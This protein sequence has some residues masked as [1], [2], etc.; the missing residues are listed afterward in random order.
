MLQQCW[1][2]NSMQLTKKCIVLRNSRF[3]DKLTIIGH[4]NENTKSGDLTSISVECQFYLTLIIWYRG[5]DFIECAFHY[6]IS[7]R[8]ASR[9][10]A[11][12]SQFMYKKFNDPEFKDRMCKRRQDFPQ[13]LPPPF[14]VPLLK[15]IRFVGDCTSISIEKPSNYSLQ[16]TTWEAYK[17]DNTV[18]F[19]RVDDPFGGCSFISEAYGGS[20]SDKEIF[21]QCGIKE[22]IEDGDGFLLDRYI[23]TILFSFF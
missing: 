18:K 19:F 10:F 11:T 16:A 14:R 17:N 3:A 12:W 6:K 5:Y 15:N 9:V 23:F 1:I 22:K 7:E 2:D 8:T 4:P 20:I 13:P 21:N